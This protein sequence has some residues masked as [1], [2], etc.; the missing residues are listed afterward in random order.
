MKKILLISISGILL[1]CQ[2][3]VAQITEIQL[4]ASDGQTLDLF[5]Q[6]VDIKG[7][8]VIVGAHNDGD[9][10]VHSGSAYIFEKVGSNWVETQKLTADDGEAEDQFGY[11]AAIWQD[12]V[13]VS[14]IGDDDNGES[15]GSAYVFEKSGGAWSQVAK[16][17]PSDGAAGDEFGCSVSIYED[18]IVVGAWKHDGPETDSGA[19]YVFKKSGGAWTQTVKLT[20]DTLD[21]FDGDYFGI[22][23]DISGE[24]IAVG[25]P[26]KYTLPSQYRHG[27]VLIF[28]ESGTTWPQTP[29]Y[30]I[31]PPYPINN[32]SGSQYGHSVSIYGDMLLVG[33]HGNADEAFVS[34]VFS[35]DHWAQ[36]G[37][38]VFSPVPGSNEDFG[39]SVGIAG[40]YA[41]V[42]APFNNGIG[43]IYIYELLDR[44][45]PFPE[46]W[47][48]SSATKITPSTA[49]SNSNAGRAVAISGKRIIVGARH[50][51]VSKGAAYIY[52]LPEPVA[53]RG[54]S[55]TVGDDS[56]SGDGFG[57]PVSISGRRF[58]TGAF[59]NDDNGTDSGSAYVF[60]YKGRDWTQTAKLL[61]DDG[62]EDDWFGRSVS[63]VGD[64]AV[65]GSPKDD[66]HGSAYIFKK[67]NDSWPL[68]QKIT[69][70]NLPSETFGRSVSI[71]NDLHTIIV[72]APGADDQ[73]GRVYIFKE[74]DGYWTGTAPLTAGDGQAGDIFG[75]SVSISQDIAIVG[76]YMDDNAHGSQ[77]GAAYIFEKVGANWVETQKLT[78]DDG[79]AEDHFGWAVDISDDRAVVGADGSG[80]SA[81][82]AAYIF[83]KTGSTWTKEQKIATGRMGE[84]FGW[85]VSIHH[86]RLVVGTWGSV[87]YGSAYLY[88]YTGTDW[89]LTDKLE[90]YDYQVGTGFG[91]AVAVSPIFTLVGAPG[92]SDN[93]LDSG[94]VYSFGKPVTIVPTIHLLLSDLP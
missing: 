58:I 43:A 7:D 84:Y 56:F 93:G 78:A 74:N 71:S 12:S 54:Q 79:E 22:S 52:E 25:A 61:P 50:N 80:G 11:S 85:A 4:L 66:N 17:T 9:L 91:S 47:S 2:T 55:K 33:A 53:P 32:W 89:V 81:E 57:D 21:Q 94:A 20:A 92:A 77:A 83:K 90:P 38:E 13:V 62:A 23:V 34:Y 69:G 88:R 60:E 15:S 68:A 51:D 45:A 26:G 72:G 64:L 27:A 5:G 49:T 18:V 65:V 6:S 75:I 31:T 86:N 87:P 14:A 24:I 19:A 35:G 10:G 82:G 63:I 36:A 16:L 73:K 59:K 1:F 29:T 37:H 67:D 8:Q 70:S 41:V 3:V 48:W 42:G 76:A 40:V 28:N 39:Y 30:K 46:D 44:Q